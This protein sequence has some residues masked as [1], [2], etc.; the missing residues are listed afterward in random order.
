M[1]MCA[2]DLKNG[3]SIFMGSHTA[4]VKFLVMVG[5]SD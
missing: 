2:L 4:T 5:T 3:V 1:K